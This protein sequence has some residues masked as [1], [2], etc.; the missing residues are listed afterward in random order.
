MCV[1]KCVPSKGLGIYACPQVRLAESGR[2]SASE[3]GKTRE[4]ARSGAPGR[5]CACCLQDAERNWE[6]AM[7][8]PSAREEPSR[9][10]Y[11][12]IGSSRRA[13]SL[14][15]ALLVP[16]TQGGQARQSPDSSA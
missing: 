15:W 10:G 6:D 9:A 5:A 4:K 1:R 2:W 13:R 11:E 12:V 8:V 14:V 16:G 7:H 3:D